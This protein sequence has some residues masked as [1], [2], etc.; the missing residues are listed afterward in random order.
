LPHL[1]VF[2]YVTTAVTAMMFHK[3]FFLRIRR[4]TS[5][6]RFT[7]FD[8]SS[9]E[10]RSDERYRRAALTT[11]TAIIARGI[12]VLT[13]LVSVPLTLNYLGIERYGLWMT[14]SSVVIMLT[15][16]DFGLGNG[17]VNAVSQSDGKDDV[18]AAKKAVSSVFFILLGSAFFLSAAFAFVYR[19]VPW[20]RMFNV[21]SVLAIRESGPT[22]A[23]FFVCFAMNLPLGIAQRV[24]IGYQEGYIN[25]CWQI[26]GNILGLAV[27]IASIACKAG[28]P[29]LVFALTGVPAFVM[30]INFIVQFAYLR[31]WLRPVWDYFDRKI[32]INMLRTG[33][34]F[35]LITL[36]NVLGTST[37]NI[38][39]AQHLGASSVATY[40]VVQRL[41]SLTLLV[42]FI[43]APLWPAFS[44][45]MS[46]GD[47]AWVNRT[48]LR[49]QNIALGITTIMALLLILFGRPIIRIWAGE[50]V[51]PSFSLLIGYALYRVVGNLNES[52]IALMNTNRFI[53]QQLLLITISGT[54][55]FVL[56]L[57]FVPHWQ[58][59]GVAWASVIAYG[60]LFNIP[61]SLTV[62]KGLNVSS[63]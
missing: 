58:A 39:I 25:N 11:V 32:G 12:S 36:A 41:F 14:V 31:P 10:G 22:A 27:L 57:A 48:F 9:D 26:V 19:F 5:L 53:R 38:I 33:L 50:Q 20:S 15:F 60:I 6:I 1:L 52:L 29:W 23:V 28:L 44:E 54:A 30:S 40:A 56:K 46:H 13:G 47:F 62:R 63:N 16:A 37:D 42:Q 7:S 2:N 21:T 8:T 4:T 59:A 17:L 24:Q 43:I 51:I 18:I 3:A 55:A 49:A 61:A 35:M 45:A 34:I